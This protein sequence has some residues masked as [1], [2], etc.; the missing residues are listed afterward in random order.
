MRHRFPLF[1]LGF[2]PYTSEALEVGEYAVASNLSPL[3]GMGV[4][5]EP[6]ALGF[7]QEARTSMFLFRK[8]LELHPG[9]PADPFPG[10][11]DGPLSDAAV[12]ETFDGMWNIS[13]TLHETFGRIYP[14]FLRGD[15]KHDWELFILFEGQLY[16]W[17]SSNP[18]PQRYENGDRQGAFLDLVDLD[19]LPDAPAPGKG[20]PLQEAL[21]S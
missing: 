11:L 19:H 15:P 21:R 9:F 18:L 13:H 3:H 10:V 7:F 4:G 8:W 6:M 14:Q 5:I 12:T 20:T 1:A 2:Q 17:Y 16:D